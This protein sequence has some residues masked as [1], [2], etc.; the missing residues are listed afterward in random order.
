[1]VHLVFGENARGI[2]II[3][4]FWSAREVHL[5]DGVDIIGSR[6]VSSCLG[7]FPVTFSETSRLRVIEFASF[8][9]EI[10]EHPIIGSFC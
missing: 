8:G 9:F 2:P 7:L 10:D 1:M 3:D 5:P 6:C 4:S